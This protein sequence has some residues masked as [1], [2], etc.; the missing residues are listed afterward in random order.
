L[1]K[2]DAVSCTASSMALTR[3]APRIWDITGRFST[4]PADAARPESRVARAF[5]SEAPRPRPVMTEVQGE[6]SDLVSK[7]RHASSGQLIRAVWA[8]AL[9][10]DRLKREWHLICEVLGTV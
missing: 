2:E 8:G 4:L 9:E 5:E 6:D 1:L 10:E 3:G 7:G